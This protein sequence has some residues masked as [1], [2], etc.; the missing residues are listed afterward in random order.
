MPCR[1]VGLNPSKDGTH[2]RLDGIDARRG[3][4]TPGADE[5]E[6]PAGRPAERPGLPAA[7]PI[8][9]SPPP[10]VAGIAPV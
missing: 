4:W 6:G 7:T 10:T 5:L 9:V 8:T 3:H 1:D 2:R